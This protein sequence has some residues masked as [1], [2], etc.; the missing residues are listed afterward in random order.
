MSWQE[1]PPFG[2][3]NPRSSLSRVPKAFSYLESPLKTTLAIL[4]LMGFENEESIVAKEDNGSARSPAPSPL[5]RS[6]ES[7]QQ[8]AETSKLEAQ[9]ESPEGAAATLAL[10][11]DYRPPLPPRPTNLSLLQEG[12]FSPGNTLQVPKRSARPQLQSTATTA[13]SRTDIHTQSHQDESGE[14]T[15]S[16][17]Q[18]TPPTKSFGFGSLRR[19]KGFASSEEG[20]SGSIRS[21]APTLETGGDV[22]S[23]LGE[24][25]GATQESPAWKMLS[26]QVEVLDPFDSMTY[27]DNELTASFYREFDEIQE[28]APEADTGG[29]AGHSPLN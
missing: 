1:T 14:T 4:S 3:R 2:L 17:T 5:S 11:K 8:P 12:K 10:Q 20:D 21:Y 27:E 9:P 29:M 15:V 22:E 6:D 26:A 18:T 24:V 16:S 28:V 19:S 23:L 7:T 13:L 25:L